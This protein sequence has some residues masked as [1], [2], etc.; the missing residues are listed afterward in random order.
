MR[1]SSDPKVIGFQ[2]HPPLF[3][4][5]QQYG[6]AQRPWLALA[7]PAQQKLLRHSA[8]QHRIHQQHIATFYVGPPTERHFASLMTSVIH[9]ANIRA[10]KVANRRRINLAY[11]IR[12][13]YKPPIHRDHYIQT[14][15]TRGP[16]TLPSP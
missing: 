10:N 14:L 7:E 13:E 16:R 11:E 12:P 2:P 1:C 4:L 15:A 6:Q 9:V 8:V 5:V 3:R